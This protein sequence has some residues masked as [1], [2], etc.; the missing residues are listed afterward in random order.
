MA[1]RIAI[2]GSGICGMSAALTL[3]ARGHHVTLTERDTAPPEVDADE[4]F[5]SWQRNGAA[6][7]RHPHAFLGLLS[8]LIARNHPELLSELYAAGARRV[9]FLDMLPAELRGDYRPDKGDDSV[10]MLM[11][12]RATMEMVMRRLVM[13]QAN[14]RIVN[15]ARVIAI[16]TQSREGAC[17][18]TGVRFIKD[19]AEHA[20]NA[21][22]VVDASGR[23]SP[24]PKWFANI[25]LPVPEEKSDAQIVYYTR[26]YRLKPGRHEPVREDRS[27]AG[28]LGYLKFGVFPGESGHFAII[29]CVPVVEAAL[30]RAV[31]DPQL[32]D[33]ICLSLP[34]LRPWL[35]DDQAEPTTKPFGI[36][37]IHA[38]W[39][40]YA[41]NGDP[42]ALNFFAIGDASIRTNPLYGRGC[43]MGMLHT[44]LLV[45]ALARSSDPVRR[46]RL[47]AANTRRE[48][49]PMFDASVRQDKR[50]VG[51]FKELMR[52][53][54][55][56]RP[57]SLR[58]WLSLALE[59]AVGAAARE[60]LHVARG[61]LRSFHLLE[62][63]GAFLS[64][65]D[66]R[67]TLLRYLLRGRKR[68]AAK[69]PKRGPERLEMH[70]SLDLAPNP[71]TN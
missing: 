61:A 10:W 6:Q 24:F 56:Q 1:E 60:H 49:R 43:S 11:C 44:N 42:V 37:D 41:P 57:K 26:H 53:S 15:R 71:P 7:F 54:K 9:D 68:N 35:A 27:D 58:Q 19:G 39:R 31:R 46:A 40:D 30:K 14:V 50:S 29:L 25:G 34:G 12:R 22:V 5:F 21:D 48:L 70:R 52:T 28:D 45:D 8:N 59:D 38:V 65:W 20:L 63:P 13:A 64:R 17:F 69:R 47:F 4:A 51:R 62:P 36:G 18:A 32:F 23:R 2:V 55:P 66:V 67:L 3:A 16:A 33:R